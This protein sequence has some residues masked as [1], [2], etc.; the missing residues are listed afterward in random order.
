MKDSH[1]EEESAARRTAQTR[2]IVKGERVV[3][4]APL[5]RPHRCI[6][7]D[8]NE[9]K[10][11]LWAVSLDGHTA[12]VLAKNEADAERIAKKALE[13]PML[14]MWLQRQPTDIDTP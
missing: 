11:A 2:R 12:D 7:N 10:P 5:K 1:R 9:L 6:D 13:D 14:P 8:G 3:I 4:I